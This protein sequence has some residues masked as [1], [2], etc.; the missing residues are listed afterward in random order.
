M[1]NKE[2]QE[3]SECTS[4]PCLEEVNSNSFNFDSSADFT[5]PGLLSIFIGLVFFFH[6]VAVTKHKAL[7]GFKW[8]VRH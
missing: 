5:K 8:R 4:A 7:G 1:K 6:L 3:H 2:E